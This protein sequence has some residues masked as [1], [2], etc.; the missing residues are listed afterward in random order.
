MRLLFSWQHKYTHV[1]SGI[2]VVNQHIQSAILF[3]FDPLEQFFNLFVVCGIADNWQTVSAP[4]LYLWWEQTCQLWTAERNPEEVFDTTEKKSIHFP[5]AMLSKSCT[6][7]GQG[8]GTAD[9]GSW[10]CLL[11]ND[12]AIIRERLVNNNR[13]C[14][15]SSQWPDVAPIRN[16]TSAAVCFRVFSW[17]PVM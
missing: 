11:Q 13:L 12:G 9:C 14:R 8:G 10:G 15:S 5:V 2:G 7:N 3:T 1:Y 17:R 16:F 6:R 4:L